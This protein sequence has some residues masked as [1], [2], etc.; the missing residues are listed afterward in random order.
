[1]EGQ[2]VEKKRRFVWR[3]QKSERAIYL[4]TKQDRGRLELRLEDT[5]VCYTYVIKKSN[6]CF[7]CTASVGNWKCHV[8]VN[9]VKATIQIF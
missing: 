1:M 8:H 9:R 6:Y 3:S 4:S 7:H 2:F 5:A